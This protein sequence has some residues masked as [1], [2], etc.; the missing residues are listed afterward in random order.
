MGDPNRLPQARDPA[1]GDFPARPDSPADAPR[2]ASLRGRKNA[3]R[4]DPRPAGSMLTARWQLQ[5][6]VTSILIFPLPDGRASSALPMM[7]PG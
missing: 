6:R 1:G 4:N 3:G 2:P 5:R 7:V